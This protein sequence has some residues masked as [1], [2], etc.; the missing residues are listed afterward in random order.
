MELREWEWTRTEEAEVGIRMISPVL[1]LLR[2][3]NMDC[4]SCEIKDNTGLENIT[5]RSVPSVVHRVFDPIGFTSP[6]LIHPK[7]IFQSTSIP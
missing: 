6:A 3:K 1:G 7:M 5:K 2:N 4:L